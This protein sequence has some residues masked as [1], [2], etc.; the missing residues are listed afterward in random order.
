MTE[1]SA[2][3]EDGW[4]LF[5]ILSPTGEPIP[6][7]TDPEFDIAEWMFEHHDEAIVAEEIV[8]DACVVTSFTSMD[9]RTR[10]MGGPPLLWETTI[11]G[12]KHNGGR[13]CYPSVLEAERS[14]DGI[15]RMLKRE[16]EIGRF[17]ARRLSSLK[18]VHAH[19]SGGKD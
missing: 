5:Y 8:G 17:A 14:H 16:R 1:Q 10:D 13:W 6:A 9:A 3:R 18:A 15:V 11:A 2:L 19:D 4:P 7:P 12:G